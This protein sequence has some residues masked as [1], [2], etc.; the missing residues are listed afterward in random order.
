[1][2]KPIPFGKYLLLDKIATGGM[3]EIFIARSTGLSGFEKFVAIKRIL[4]HHASN[5]AFLSMFLD[6]ARITVGLHH[7]NIV[8]IYDFGDIEGHYFLAMEYVE[9]K[10]L[11]EILARVEENN[12]K[13]PLEH[14]IY[15]ASEVAKGLD[16]AHRK[17]DEKN[18]IPLKIVHRDVSPQNVLAS[19][20]GELKLID[21]GIAQAGIEN[22]NHKGILKGKFSYMSPEQATGSHV[23]SRSDIF[24]CGILLYELLTAQKLFTAQSD[25]SVLSLIQSA[26]IPSPS[27]LNPLIPKSLESILYKALKK[28]VNQRYQRA[29]DF[30]KD[31]TQLLYQ[32]HP[33]YTSADLA[34]YLQKTFVADVVAHKKKMK[35]I[36]HFL[37]EFSQKEMVPSEQ[38]SSKGTCDLYTKKMQHE[39]TY[40]GQKPSGDK[41]NNKS[42]Y[43]VRSQ[44][45]FQAL[46]M[47]WLRVG[48]LSFLILALL[49]FW[50][51]L[52]KKYKAPRLPAK[53]EE[54]KISD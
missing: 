20:E 37:E 44:R 38:K 27:L 16:Y 26:A 51:Q 21:F 46:A 14:A 42:Q 17:K 19:Y 6:E 40:I 53:V 33:S 13:L 7:S 1:M 11:R 24:S 30:H 10:N 49:L 3:A 32:L 41:I 15:I 39:A 45:P 9:G 22:E 54:K 12:E 35:E 31:L 50:H 8:Q 25:S 29:L 48:I 43:A 28:D 23:D 2:I 18:H 5:E 52:F 4:P 47:T 34:A 36:I